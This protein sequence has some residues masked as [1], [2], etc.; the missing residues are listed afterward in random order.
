MQEKSMIYQETRTGWHNKQNT[1]NPNIS[2]AKGENYLN[3]KV[4]TS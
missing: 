1:E 3:H 4:P 2:A